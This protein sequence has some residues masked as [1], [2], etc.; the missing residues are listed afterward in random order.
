VATT[1]YQVTA[2]IPANT[3][4]NALATVAATIPMCTV[5]Q[6]DIEVPPG[7]QGLMGFYLAM[8][9]QQIIPMN[10]GQFIV[11]DN[12]RDTWSLD[13]YPETGA[14]QVVG[15]NLDGAF[16]HEVVLRFHTDPLEVTAAQPTLTII[17]QPLPQVPVTL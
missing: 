11:W 4:Q 3:P 7:P 10:P 12:Y 9:G 1:I 15:Y 8:S 13:D 14:W 2:S 5:D 16:A 6:V 17:T